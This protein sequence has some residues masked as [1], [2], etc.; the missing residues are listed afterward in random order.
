MFIPTNSDGQI[1]VNLIMKR[2]EKTIKKKLLLSSVS[3]PAAKLLSL[4]CVFFFQ[5]GPTCPFIP[6]LGPF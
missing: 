6:L 4:V 2:I 3:S 5:V 1:F